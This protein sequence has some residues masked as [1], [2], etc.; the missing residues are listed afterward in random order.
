MKWVTRPLVDSSKAFKI[1]NGRHPVVELAIK[2]SSGDMFVPNDCDLSEK[3]SLWLLTG[4]NMAG[5][6]TFLRQNA[7]ITILSQIGSYVPA[8][9]AHIGIVDK[10]FSR[11]GASGD[12][13]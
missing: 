4:P 8:E 3:T 10:L 6:S 7:L 11:V 2:E 12:L 1:S 5:K 13:A 9:S